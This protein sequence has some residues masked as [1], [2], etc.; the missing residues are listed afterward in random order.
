MP[1]R[2]SD[3]PKQR[4][5]HRREG[6]KREPILTRFKNAT[7]KLERHDSRL[8]YQHDALQILQLQPGDAGEY[9][10]NA[11]LE[12][13]LVVLTRTFTRKLTV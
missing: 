9:L 10:C 4:W 2:H 13:T 1:C 3:K 8:S 11:E 5:Y 6:G 7:V 12:A